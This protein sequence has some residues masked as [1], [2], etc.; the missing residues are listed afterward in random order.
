[1]TKGRRRYRRGYPLAVLVGLEENRAV[2]WHVFSE[3]VKLDGMVERGGELY[4]FHESIVN[5]LRPAFKEGTKSIVVV[6]PARTDYSR[7]F[8][9]HVRRHHA[10]LVREGPNAATFGELIG[11]ADQPHEV[12]ELVKTKAFRQIIVETTS[13]D[14]SNIA[15]VMEKGLSSDDSGTVVSYSLEQ[16][17]DLVYGRKTHDNLRPE[18][19]VLTEKYLAD[20][21]NRGRILR[22]LQISKNNGI[23]TTIVNAESSAGVRL[24]QLGGLVCFAKSNRKKRK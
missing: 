9:D 16:I 17:E 8:L 13:R 12:H 4:D 6:A 18:H 23:K 1:L 10:W 21:M 3:V 5:A 22:L 11:S 19:I 20:P 15:G 24:S 2:L 14:A 7:V